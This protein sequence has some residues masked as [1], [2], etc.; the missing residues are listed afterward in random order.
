MEQRSDRLSKP[1]AV[2]KGIA[3]DSDRLN[4]NLI[5]TEVYEQLKDSY[6]F[7]ERGPVEVKG[8]GLIETWLLDEAPSAASSPAS[9]ISIAKA[10]SRG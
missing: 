8:K 6:R 3:G 1:V 5:G 7:R 4:E 10:S 2:E 9:T